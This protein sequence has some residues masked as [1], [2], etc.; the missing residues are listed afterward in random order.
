MS[1]FQIA[2]DGPAGA[3]KSTVARLVAKQLGLTYVDT[4]AMYRGIAWRALKENISISHED[5]LSALAKETQFQ[6]ENEGIRINGQWLNEELRTPQVSQLASAIAKMAKVR[7]ALVSKQQ[8]IARY[9]NVVMDGRDIGT[10]VLPHANI[11]VFLTASIEKRAHRRFLELQAKG[12]SVNEK[13]LQEEIR[14]RDENDRKRKHSPLRK[15]EDAIL[16]DTTE[17]SIPEVVEK[18]LELCRTKVG[19]GE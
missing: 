2:I 19:G 11:K 6:L 7:Q 17:Q 12:L 14:K 4:G 5:A 1:R 9:Q 3:G 10:H 16:I 8:E 18:I 15:A 13:T